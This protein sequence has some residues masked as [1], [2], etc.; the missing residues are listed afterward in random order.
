MFPG[1]LAHSITGRA[2][3]QNICTLNALNIR[4]YAEDKHKTVDDSPFG[5]GVGMV[6]KPDVVHRAL[7]FAYGQYPLKPAVIYF[8]PRGETLTQKMLRHLVAQYS[9]GAIFL[10]GRY[11][12]IDQRVIDYGKENFDLMEISMGDYVLTGGEL[13][14]MSMIDAWV[15]LLPGVLI[16]ENATL[17][18]SFELDL[19]EHPQYT[20]PRNWQGMVV[21][22][23][24]LSGDHK[25]IAAWQREQAE[26]ITQEIRPDLWESFKNTR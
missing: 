16:K 20:K 2:L 12:G 5:G 13:P 18:E 23:V 19:L 15:R 24:L 1:P 17:N 3:D 21:P 8:T 22:D 7:D 10:C 26:K 25:K 14:A 9:K 11:E 6:L 4:D